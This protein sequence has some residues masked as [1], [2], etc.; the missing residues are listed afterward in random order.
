[1]NTLQQLER[2]AHDRRAEFNAKLM[3]VQNRLTLRGLADEAFVHLDHRFARALP[4]YSAAK[5]H[6]LLAA[7]AIASVAWL[8]KQSTLSS[9]KIFKGGRRAF[10][11]RNGVRQPII[12]TSKKGD[13]S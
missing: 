12:L 11:H 1:M 4:V 13:Q 7:G 2:N 8:F 10:R 9:S 6:P 5:R 3:Q